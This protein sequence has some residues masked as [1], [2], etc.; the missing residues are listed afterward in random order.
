[1]L[2][3]PPCERCGLAGRAAVPPSGHRT[4]RVPACLTVGPKVVGKVRLQLEADPIKM[5]ASRMDED[6]S[7]NHRHTGEKRAADIPR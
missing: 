1:M 7:K 5:A 4:G 6:A 3:G 2:L